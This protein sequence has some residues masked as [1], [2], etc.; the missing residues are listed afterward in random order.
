[1]KNVNSEFFW[2][3]DAPLQELYKYKEKGLKEVL[4]ELYAQILI[5]FFS[6]DLDSLKKSILQLSLLKSQNHLRQQEI[7]FVLDLAELRYQIRTHQIDRQKILCIFKKIKNHSQDFYHWMAEGYCLLARASELLQKR[8][9][10]MRY[11]LQAHLLFSEQGCH[12]KAIRMM[13]NYVGTKSRLYPDA[14]YISENYEV[15]QLAR[16]AREYGMA[17][18]AFMNISR[19]LQAM[20]AKMTALR[21]ANRAVLFMTRDIGSLH[22]YLALVHRC[23]LLIELENIHDAILDYEAAKLSQHYEVLAAV[24]HLEAILFKTDTMTREEEK[25]LT[26]NWKARRALDIQEKLANPTIKQISIHVL[27]AQEDQLVKLLT[28]KPRTKKEI[29]TAIWGNSEDS[30]SLEMR[31]KDLIKRVRR[32]RKDF[33]LFT[34]ESYRLS[35]KSYIMIYGKSI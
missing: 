32:K 24:K 34:G 18:V 2:L 9:Q 27:A 7:L 15:I 20:G 4:H 13:M 26:F 5:S 30:F 35:D 17:G 33:I 1:M 12:R 29:I 21:F 8:R 16:K 11:Y 22:Y 14:N 3:L 23:H 31:F 6:G 10:S 28:L 25:N 19:E